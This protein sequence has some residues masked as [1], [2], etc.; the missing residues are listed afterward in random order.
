[1]REKRLGGGSGGQTPVV[2]RKL[3]DIDAAGDATLR[4]NEGH[5]NDIDVVERERDLW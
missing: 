3:C 5:H 4:L 2:G 1:V